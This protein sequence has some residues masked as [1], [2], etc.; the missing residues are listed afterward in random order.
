[1]NSL[2]DVPAPAKIN[3]FL[4]VTGQRPDGLHH[5][6]T[7]FVLLDL[8]DSLDFESCAAPSITRE[9]VD[10]SPNADPLP[11][12]DLCTRAAR[13]LQQTTGYPGGAHIR[14]TKRIPSQAGLGGGS[15][16]AASC[17]IALNRLWDTRLNRIALL[18]LA[19]QLGADVP[20][21]IFGQ[22]AWAEGTGD[23]LQPLPLPRSRY[24]VAKPPVGLSTQLIFQH[25]SLKRDTQPATIEGFAEYCKSGTNLL[26]GTN[27][28]Q[29]VAQTLCP[30]IQ[31]GLS[32]FASCG[33]PARMT[34][35]G[36]AVFA[37]INASDA[38]PNWPADWFQCICHS[39]VEHPLKNWT[40]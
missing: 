20:F 32:L 14:L 26:F 1:M 38:L 36:S 28:L 31:Q 33:L 35:S 12:D 11:D 2:L 23:Q 39:L 8:A 37:P 9:D 13:L 21:F 40:D 3:L 5:L 16:D 34:G 18:Q 29:S 15:S 10:A 25:R 19:S 27:D 22:T 7:A 24:L 30:E 4:H 6:Q 17:L